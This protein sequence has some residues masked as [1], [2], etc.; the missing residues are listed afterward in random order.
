MNYKQQRM[1]CALEGPRYW[2]RKNQGSS[3]TFTRKGPLTRA[4][5]N[6]IIKELQKQQSF[7]PW[8]VK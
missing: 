4:F 6:A 5:I 2:H 3:Y 8:F 7:W 1:W